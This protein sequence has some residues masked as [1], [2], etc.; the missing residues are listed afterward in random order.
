ME[1][2]TKLVKPAH[3]LNVI[4]VFLI[5]IVLFLIIVYF[6]HPFRTFSKYFVTKGDSYLSQ[7]KYVSANLEYDKALMLNPKNGKAIHRKEITKNA[8]TDIKALIPFW[9][10]TNNQ[11]MLAK[12]DKVETFPRNENE[13]LILSKKL[14][15]ESEYQL[16]IIPAE[17]AVAM[18]PEYETAQTYLKIA[19][20]KAATLTEISPENQ[21]AYLQQ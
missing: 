10:E 11:E 14:M 1:N 13:A 6:F 19:K 15:E 17:T 3:K 5:A 12:M 9:T 21:S 18:A 16:A 7:K 8:E 2:K 4:Y 20:E